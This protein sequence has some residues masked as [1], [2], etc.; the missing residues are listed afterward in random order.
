M[1][2]AWAASLACLLA[3]SSLSGCGAAPVAGPDWVLEATP[4]LGQSSQALSWPNVA[5]NLLYLNFEGG[6]VVAQAGVDNAVADQSQLG[7]SGAWAAFD[8]TVG[9]PSTAVTRA[10]AIAAVADRV[11]SYYH[12]F[13]LDVVTTR[14]SSGPYTMILVGG[15]HTDI[16][17]A[18]GS[19]VIGVSPL[20]CTNANK[21]NLVFDFA[22]DQTL[23][24]GGLV[25][26][27]ATAAHEAGHSFGLEHTDNP[28]D[29]MYSVKNGTA[30]LQGQF[31]LSFTT[32]N[33][34]SFNGG[35]PSPIPEMCGRANPLDNHAILTTNLGPRA[36]GGDTVA[37]TLTLDLPGPSQNVPLSFPVL[38]TAA[39][40]VAL[41]RVEVYKNFEL[42]AVLT[43]PTFGFTMGVVDK[44]IFQ[45]AF[46]AIDTSAN[47]TQ[48]LRVLTADAKNPPLC[49]TSAECAG[50]RSCDNNLCRL[51]LGA[52]CKSTA[53]CAGGASCQ[54]PMGQTASLC[55]QTCS[56]AVPCPMG[57]DCVN[58]LCVPSS[59][60]MT[61]K[62]PGDSCS[63]G[64]ECSSGRCQGV[65]VVACDAANPCDPSAICQ[66]VS[67]GQGCVPSDG[68][69]T[70]KGCEVGAGAE[71]GRD[72]L[73][74][75]LLCVGLLGGALRRRVIGSPR[76]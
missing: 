57:L 49:Q 6:D 10:Q 40:D 1:S 63:D 65:C 67:G 52:A 21:S 51:P 64:S 11:R 18:Q 38:V 4:Q 62:L 9:A 39:D 36:P 55:T 61:L 20:D 47:R 24:Y 16:S 50:G 54:T 56:G 31:Q 33:Y 2:R 14:P 25:E 15:T 44:E 71:G 34:S 35:S 66:D 12:P 70:K 19:G 3:A 53:D 37:P 26:V 69:M 73:W 58:A 74:P 72:G 43:P 68:P 8:K 46:E 29:L 42:I 27:A 22:S 7:S 76:R 32:G 48:V 45:L 75:L 5:P 30:T 23:M 13:N 17:P 41:S 59:M 60:P 28:L